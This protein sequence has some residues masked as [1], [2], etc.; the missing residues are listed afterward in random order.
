MALKLDEYRLLGRSG[1]RVS[2]ICF[3]TMTFGAGDWGS[4]NEEAKQMVDV[5]IDR[6]G[7]FKFY[8]EGVTPLVANLLKLQQ[9]FL[10]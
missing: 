7:N 9:P 6:G 1:L 3:G 10:S 2:P 4:T 8:G 5:Y